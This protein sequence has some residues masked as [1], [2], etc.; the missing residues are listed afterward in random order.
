MHVKNPYNFLL[1]QNINNI[2]SLV[3]KPHI[4]KITNETITEPK[5]RQYKNKKT[6]KKVSSNYE[7]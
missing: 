7:M 2:N 1:V 4:I 3:S 6:F 5:T